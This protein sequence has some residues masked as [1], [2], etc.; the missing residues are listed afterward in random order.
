MD[1]NHKIGNHPSTNHT[2]VRF[3]GIDNANEWL[4]FEL[5][6]GSSRI[7]TDK[8]G[9]AEEGVYIFPIG[10]SAWDEEKIISTARKHDAAKWIAEKTGLKNSNALDA[11]NALVMWIKNDGVQKKINELPYALDEAEDETNGRWNSFS[12][13]T[14]RKFIESYGSI[15]GFKDDEVKRIMTAKALYGIFGFQYGRCKKNIEAEKA[16]N[17][18]WN[19]LSDETKADIIA[20]YGS[21]ENYK[22]RDKERYKMAHALKGLGDMLKTKA[23]TIVDEHWDSL[24]DDEKAAIIEEFGSESNYK[25]WKKHTDNIMRKCLERKNV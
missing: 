13:A 23:D 15:A 11:L 14:K 16:V 8:Y 3:I 22:A 1:E 17:D 6:D 12:D 18:S 2:A 10:I 7:G 20:E 25:A 5:R 21:E 24:S 19:A 9:V 4:V